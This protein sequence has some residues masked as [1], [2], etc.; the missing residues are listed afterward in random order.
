MLVHVNLLHTDGFCVEGS[1]PEKVID[2]LKTEFGTSNVR[3]DKEE[4]LIDPF[5]ENWFKETLNSLTP[6][7]NLRFYRKQKKM[8][9]L[10]LEKEIGTTKQ[11]ICAMEHDSRAISKKTAKIL[12]DLFGTSPARFI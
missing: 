8:T 3:V 5:E 9:Q 1:V 11:A 7:K 6:G 12:A 4:E 2:F 10:S